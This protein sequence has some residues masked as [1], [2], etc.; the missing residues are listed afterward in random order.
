[1]TLQE[2]ELSMDQ[3]LIQRV[4]EAALL[5]AP[6]PLTLAQLAA[7]FHEDELPPAG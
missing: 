1:M 3:D 6:Q 2:T 4:V 7:L 5:A